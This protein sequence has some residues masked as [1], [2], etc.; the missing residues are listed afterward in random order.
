MAPSSP[1]P[2]SAAVLMWLIPD[3]NDWILL[4]AT[5]VVSTMVTAITVANTRITRAGI[6]PGYWAGLH[7]PVSPPRRARLQGVSNRVV[8]TG[9]A[10]Q[11]G[12]LL[13]AE[14]Q[15]S[16][17]EVLPLTSSQWNIAD[18]A[19]APPLRGGDVVVNC[20]A[21]T[22]VDAAEADPAAAY[23][24]NADGA[25]QVASACARAGARLI[26]I[27]TDY[28]FS[29]VLGPAGAIRS[30]P[31]EPDDPTGPLNVYGR[32][33]LAGEMAVLAAAPDALV[34]RTSWLFTGAAGND[35]AAVIAGKARR[36]ESVEVVADQIGTPTYTADLVG[37]LSQIIA[38][39]GIRGP[40][41]HAANAGEASRYDQARA[42]FEELGADPELV[43]PV[44][45][46][47]YPRPAPR[48]GYSALGSRR[49]AAAGL[50]PLR[51]WR[52]ALREALRRGQLPST[53]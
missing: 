36:G 23:A 12:R 43:R 35:F 28:V 41:L 51:G 25:A 31:Y 2:P 17:P 15:R 38:E 3:S 5:P 27:S 18:P 29:G 39:T 14:A 53:P 20:A 4:Q 6:S 47:R 44:P 50:T 9:A 26:H 49:S 45:A 37:A 34:V 19:A 11:L 10:G 1:A 24:V 48:P 40:I 8:I 46:G 16:H 22:N 21:Y 13:V 33:K 42:V 30:R 52:D 7:Y 32:S